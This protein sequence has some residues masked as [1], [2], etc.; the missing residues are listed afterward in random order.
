MFLNK[1]R[2]ITLSMGLSALDLCVTK[3]VQRAH[4]CATHYL[5][6][7]DHFFSIKPAAINILIVSVFCTASI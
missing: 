5:A 7:E 6:Q 4:T 2:I 1:T 3:E